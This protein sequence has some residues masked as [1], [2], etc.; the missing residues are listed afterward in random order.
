MKL[1][2]LPPQGLLLLLFV[3]VWWSFWPNSIKSVCILCHFWPLKV[4]IIQVS[5]QLI[6][7][8]R[9]PLKP[10]TN[11]SPNFWQ[12]ALCAC[13]GMPSSLSQAVGNSALAITSSLYRTSRA[14][15]SEHLVPFWVAPENC[16]LPWACA[17]LSRS[18]GICYSLPNPYEYISQFFPL[19]LLVSLFF[20]P[21]VIHDP[22]NH[23]VTNF[24]YCFLQMPQRKDFSQ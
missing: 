17:Q 20:A 6:I 15:K 8:Q 13:W 19:S 16:T 18:P 1:E 24:L 2:S 21:T 3:A 23:N 7:R 10:R 22:G 11:E 9:F 4:L 14:A 12:R 5:S